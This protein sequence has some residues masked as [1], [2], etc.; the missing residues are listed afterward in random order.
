[1]AEQT[2]ATP[3]PARMTKVEA[4]RRALKALGKDATPSQLQ[5]Y[6]KQTFGIEMTPAH[7]TTCKGGILRKGRK[8]PGPK[9]KGQALGPT[10][11]TPTPAKA[12]AKNGIS[13][14]DIQSVKGLVG[15]VGPDQ[16]KGL[17]DLLSR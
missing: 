7:V 3:Q 13:L 6:I 8:K 11:P 5:P 17:I 10:Q 9:P 14:E 4:V 12:L 1:M 2:K 15:R 16:L